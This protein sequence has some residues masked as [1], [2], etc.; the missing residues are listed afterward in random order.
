MNIITILI[1][2][3][4]VIVIIREFKICDADLDENVTLNYNSPLS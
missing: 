3:V 2:V 4:V 1:A